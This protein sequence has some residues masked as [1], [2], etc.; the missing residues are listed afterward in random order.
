MVMKHSPLVQEAKSFVHGNDA[1]CQYALPSRLV[2]KG[3]DMYLHS[4]YCIAY[5]TMSLLC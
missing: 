4:I 2:M 1:D 3:F 5:N